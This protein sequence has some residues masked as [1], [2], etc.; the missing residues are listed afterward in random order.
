MAKQWTTKVDTPLW[1]DA[2]KS[3]DKGLVRSGTSFV[4]SDNHEGCAK[5]DRI[6]YLPKGAS[7]YTFGDGWIETKNCTEVGVI[8]PPVTPPPTTRMPTAA[9]FA[10]FKKVWKW[11]TE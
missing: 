8:Y 1:Q 6:S 11:M 2:H 4:E 5:A 7:A 10:T 9:E 3:R